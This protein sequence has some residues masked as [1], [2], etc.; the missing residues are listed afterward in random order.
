MLK[1]HQV[2]LEDWQVEYLQA[3]AEAHD[4]SVSEALRVILSMGTVCAVEAIHHEYKSSVPFPEIARML[5]KINQRPFSM[6]YVHKF[7][8][9]IYFEARKA[10]EFR[11]P[12]LKKLGKENG[13]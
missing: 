8:S 3:V 5:K 7:I 2:L 4:I 12:R 10:V 11:I 1:R 6:D 13:S 9:T